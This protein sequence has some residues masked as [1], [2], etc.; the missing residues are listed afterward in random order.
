MAST[1]DLTSRALSK[2]PMNLFNTKTPDISFPLV[3]HNSDKNILTRPADNTI[4]NLY[5]NNVRVQ[6]NTTLSSILSSGGQVD[7]II[8][9]GSVYIL[10]DISIMMSFTNSTGLSATLINSFQILDRIEF[11]GNNGSD[12]LST[13]D[14][15]KLYLNTCLYDD[16]EWTN[17]SRSGNISNVWGAGSAIAN[18]A[19][20]TYIIN[21]KGSIFNQTKINMKA[22]KGDILV[23]SYFRP[24]SITVSAGSAVTLTDY[25]LILNN[26]VTDAYDQSIKDMLYQKYQVKLRYYDQRRF[27]QSAQTLAAS[28]TY[29]YVLNNISGMVSHLYFFLRASPN[30]AATVNTFSAIS[31]FDILDSNNASIMNY[32]QTSDFNLKH[33]WS[34]KLP[35]TLFPVYNNVYLVSFGL[36]PQQALDSGLISGYFPFDS[37]QQLQI[38]TGSTFT[39]GTYDIV[40]Y[41]D[42]VTDL[43]VKN[44]MISVRK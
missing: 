44:G 10:D 2:N 17:R 25:S 21:L 37:Y 14:G 32:Q 8:K 40:V 27:L 28:T 41:A 7:N 16:A 30:V 20:A 13:I 33:E 26:I 4:L 1:N 43:D 34:E 9:A 6:S 15:D 31:S 42:V 29:T 22:V 24:T 11:Y 18:S 35:G 5:N 12:L 19:S 3:S 38:T 36:S 23:R 39:P